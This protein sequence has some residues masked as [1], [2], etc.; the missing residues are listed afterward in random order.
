M[1]DKPLA[2]FATFLATLS[3]IVGCEQ[4]IIP[5]PQNS[6]LKAIEANNN[7]ELR[8]LEAFPDGG[9][10]LGTHTSVNG[11][12]DILIMKFNS[13]FELQWQR[14]VGD[15]GYNQLDKILIDKNE[16]ILLAGVSIG[17]GEDDRPIL[18]R[19]TA[20]VAYCHLLTASGETLWEND[21]PL[22]AIWGSPWYINDV[23]EDDNG[24]FVLCGYLGLEGF[25]GTILKLTSEGAFKVYYIMRDYSILALYNA[26]DA[27]TAFRVNAIFNRSAEFVQVKKLAVN[28][29]GTYYSPVESE[30]P[31]N[32]NGRSNGSIARI[33]LIPD[34]NHYTYTYFFPD[35][36]YEYSYDIGAK[37]HTGSWKDSDFT[38]V[39]SVNS[40]HDKHFIFTQGNGKIFE[41]DSDFRTINTFQTNLN[42]FNSTFK[43][44]FVTKLVGGDYVL[45]FQK[46]K[47]IFLAHFNREGQIIGHE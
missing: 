29:V 32:T 4:S 47:N 44:N 23:I 37:T 9:F 13:V 33:K 19:S 36:I 34:N 35:E 15:M 3:L 20:A 42:V 11:Q 10:L 30:W 21:Y 31:W 27:Y 7:G 45:G 16:N 40:T 1:W 22:H 8:I 41:T 25:G 6:S 24:D 2:I 14:I 5:G 46:D 43:R 26:E 39:I 18:E 12:Q 38:D 28:G 17:F